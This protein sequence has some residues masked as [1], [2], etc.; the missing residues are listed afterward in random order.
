[1]QNDLLEFYNMVSFCNP[2]VLGTPAEFRR[3]YER[4]ILAAR[5]PDAS[6][7]TVDRATNLQKELSGIVN[8]F[9]LKRGN[10]LNAQHLPP[11]LVQ[12][13][14]CKLTPLQEKLYDELIR[15]KEY[16]FLRDAR[17]T[18]TLNSIRWMLNICS[19]PRMV[20]DAYRSKANGKEE[21]DEELSSLMEVL[22]LHDQGNG[23]APVQTLSVAPKPAAFPRSGLLGSRGNALTSASTGKEFYNPVESGKFY[24]LYKLLLTMRMYYPAERIVIVSNYTSTLDLL[25]KMCRS[26]LVAVV[27][28]VWM[29]D[30]F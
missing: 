12:F 3:R 15:G 10:I 11:K 13:V 1:M 29:I 17:H 30:W 9:I 21:I 22:R 7:S 14:C 4:P 27:C 18:N 24:V 6:S 28:V 2:G 5:E 25:E 26:V 20:Q 16:R 23:A 8:E 19:H